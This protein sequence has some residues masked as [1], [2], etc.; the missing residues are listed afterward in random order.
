MYTIEDLRNG[1]CAVENDGTL[2]ELKKVLKEAFPA[3]ECS[4]SG[5]SQFYYGKHNRVT[6]YSALYT[7][8][9][10]S[11]PTQSVKDFI[12][13]LE[14][15]P[16]RGD[17]VEVRDQDTEKWV[18]RIFLAKIEG[19][20]NPFIAVNANYEDNFLVGRKFSL[21]PWKQMRPIQREPKRE[22]TMKEIADRMGISVEEL[23]I[24]K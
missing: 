18:K 15:N 8:L 2:E 17:W 1:K 14:F 4:P 21:V 23:R 13:Q 6:W 20:E 19:A 5:D 11:L 10:T 3:D 22:Y 7:S 24:K 16:K 9:P 12:S